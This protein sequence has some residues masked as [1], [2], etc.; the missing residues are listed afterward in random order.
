MYIDRYIDI[1]RLTVDC[2]KNK[3]VEKDYAWVCDLSMFDKR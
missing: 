1:Y 3:L 2:K